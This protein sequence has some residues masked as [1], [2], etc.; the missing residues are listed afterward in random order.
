MPTPTGDFEMH[1]CP[2]C[3]AAIHADEDE[4]PV[5]DA[6]LDPALMENDDEEFPD[7]E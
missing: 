1:K 7:A 3:G 4:C 5:C 6:D 2:A